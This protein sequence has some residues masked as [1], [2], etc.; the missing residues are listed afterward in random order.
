MN[1]HRYFQHSEEALVLYRARYVMP[2]SAPLIKDGVV[3]VKNGMIIEVGSSDEVK[4]RYRATSYHDLGEV[5]LMPGLINAHTHLDCTMMKNRLEHGSS[6]TAWV[7]GLNKIKFSLQEEDI[8][9]GVTKGMSEL[10]RWGCVAA[11]NIV[12]FARLIEK[13]PSSPLRLCHFIEVMDIRGSQQGEEGLKIAGDFFQ[14]NGDEKIKLGISPHAPQTASLNLYRASAQLS[15][16][17]RVPFCTHLAESEEE[18]EMF[19]QGSGVLFD[20][21][22]DLGRDMNDTGF[23]TP[24]QA[25]LEHDVLPQGALLIHMNCL[26]SKDRQLLAQRAANFFVVHCPKT[27]RF[28]ERE[29]FNWKFFYDHGYRLSLGTDSLASNDGLNLFSEMQLFQKTAS[30]LAPQEILKMVTLNPAEALGMKGK[31]GELS[32]GSFAEMI[33]IP[34]QGKKQEVASAVIHNSLFPQLIT[35]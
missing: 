33:T 24:V 21:L 20:F 31:L 8:I 3:A 34:F 17:Y 23:Q 10:H 22:K 5:I 11:G 35:N 18:F 1:D 7:Q 13:L 29:S 9:Q 4:Q 14:K 27:H 19:A 16:Q 28:F 12:S 2:M 30:N 15:Q 6:F 25:L 32:P 26:T